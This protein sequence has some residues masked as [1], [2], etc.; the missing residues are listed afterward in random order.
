MGVFIAKEII[1]EGKIKHTLKLDAIRY[2]EM[3]YKFK[4]TN[5]MSVIMG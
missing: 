1:K 4:L 3:Y 2:V 5:P